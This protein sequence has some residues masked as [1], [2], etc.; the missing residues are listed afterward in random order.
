MVRR[1]PGLRLWTV[2][3]LLNAAA[4]PAQSNLYRQALEKY[5]Q[6]KYAEALP[7]AEQAVRQDEN[8]AADV[9]LYGLILAALNRFDEAETKLRRAVTLQPDRSAFHYDLGNLFHFQRKYDL[10]LPEL[11][12]AVELDPENLTA[13]LLLARTYVF[14]YRELQI[15]NFSELALEQLNY[16]AKRN[17]RFPAVHHHLALIY[18]N[19]GEQSKALEELNTELR[20]FPGNTQARM[21][22]GETLLRLNR[23]RQAT[24]ALIVAAR[25]A[26]EMPLVQ[27]ALAKAYKAAGQVPEAIAAAK[28]CVELQP[29]FADGHYLLGQL[30]RAANNPELAQ[31]HFERF[32]ALRPQAATP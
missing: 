16:V 26:P 12:R 15:P 6:Q 23:P 11:K 14:A 5:Q 27:Y 31:Q 29:D 19:S 25:E 10:A 1:S 21:E 4:M 17:P 24:E 28:R 22:L 30:Y 3:C 8:N 7:I 9:H 18:I 2:T 20:F 32:R 13:R